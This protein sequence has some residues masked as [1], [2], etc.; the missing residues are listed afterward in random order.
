MYECCRDL[1]C[2]P[3]S[4]DGMYNMICQRGRFEPVD[5][6]SD[7]ACRGASSH[8]NLDSYFDAHFPTTSLD[9]CKSLC[10]DTEGCHGIEYSAS[11]QRCEVWTRPEGI[12]ATK[13]VS[14]FTCLRYLGSSAPSPAPAGGERTQA[15]TTRPATT[16]QQQVCKIEGDWCHNFGGGFGA[17]YECCGDLTCEPEGHHADIRICKQPTQQQVCKPEGEFCYLAGGTVMYECC[18]DLTC[19]PDSYHGMYNMICQRGR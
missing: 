12:G 5:G 6:G 19:E 15:P 16:T 2:E 17:M 18:G 8:D 9:A 3:D 4:S 10:T 11:S 7:R 13:P 14:G 1:T